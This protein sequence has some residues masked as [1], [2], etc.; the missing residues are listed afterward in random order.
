VTVLKGEGKVPILFGTKSMSAGSAIHESYLSRPDLGGEWPTLL[1]VPSAWGVTSAVKDLARRL[2]RQG[3]AV[4]A[5]D[6][7]GRGGPDRDASAEEASLALSGVSERRGRRDLEDLVGF[8]TNP[9]GFWSNAEDGFGIVGLG[10]GGRL[11][12]TAALDTGS[13]LV[14]AGA[15]LLPGLLEQLTAPALGIF[16]KADEVIPLD[17]IM[18]ARERAPRVEWVLYDG[19]GHDFLDDYLEAFDDAAHQDT[20]ERIAAFCEEH[21]P[22]MR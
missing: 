7:Y 6:V 18:A 9:A 4:V 8:V 15:S 20:V 12:T 19:V 2:A 16:G 11:A 3:L 21:L 14:L 5:V 1:L 10:G 13:P 22:P 17:E